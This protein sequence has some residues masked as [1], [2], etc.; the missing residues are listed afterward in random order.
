MK[1]VIQKLKK[2]IFINLKNIIN[3]KTNNFILFYFILHY[4]LLF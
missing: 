2:G 3:K 1:F 4:F